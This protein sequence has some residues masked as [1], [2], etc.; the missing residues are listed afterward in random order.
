V[1]DGKPKR[2][3]GLGQKA[4]GQVGVH[5]FAPRRCRATGEEAEPNPSRSGTCVERG[6]PNRSHTEVE[7]H[8]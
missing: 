7:S 6:K 8:P 5:Q 4:R 1:N 2:L 3:T